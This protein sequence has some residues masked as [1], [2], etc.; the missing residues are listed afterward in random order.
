M[1][2]RNQFRVKPGHKFRLNKLDPAHSGK[3]KSEAEAK[4][5]TER[6]LKE[7]ARQQSLL[8]ADHK[9]SVLIVLQAMDAGGKD[10]T[11]KHVF[12]GVNPQGVSVASLQATDAGRT[13]ARLSLAGPC[14]RSGQ[15]AN[16]DFQPV[17]LRG[18][19]GRAGAQ[20]H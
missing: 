18:R 13:R 10:G 7:L 17:A 5:E 2:Y 14:S 16:R 15:R 1:D 8:Y 6:F 11:I 12:S 19:A 20:A 9:H 4:E 3:H